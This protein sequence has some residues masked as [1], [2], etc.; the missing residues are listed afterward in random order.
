MTR[1]LSEITDDITAAITK[2]NLLASELPVGYIVQYHVGH[3]LANP[4]PP[5]GYISA[6]VNKLEIR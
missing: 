3:I 2:L 4:Q 5:N 6:T 1:T